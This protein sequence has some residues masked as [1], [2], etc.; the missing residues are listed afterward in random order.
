MFIYVYQGIIF[1]IINHIL[2]TFQCCRNLMREDNNPLARC[3]NNELLQ[4]YRFSRNTILNILL[5]LAYPVDN[6]L[7]QRGL[8]IPSITKLCIALHY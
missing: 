7:N 2:N 1:T 4:R 6:P 8:P 5:P 3:N